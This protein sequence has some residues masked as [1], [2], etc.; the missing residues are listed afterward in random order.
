MPAGRRRK[1]IPNHRKLGIFSPKKDVFLVKSW[2]EISC[3][4][5]INTG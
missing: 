1:I 3:D 2:L 4:P 5:I